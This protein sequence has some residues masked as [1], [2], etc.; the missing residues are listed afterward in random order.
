[1]GTHCSRPSKLCR[2]S[3]QIPLLFLEQR[4]VVDEVLRPANPQ[5]PQLAAG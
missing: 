4:N 5:P 2:S 1:M 3:S